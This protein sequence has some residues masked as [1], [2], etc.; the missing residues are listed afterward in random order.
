MEF[1]GKILPVDGYTIKNS[2]NPPLDYMKSLTHLYQPLLGME[3]IMLYQTLLHEADLQESA[4]VQTHHTLMNYLNIA[5]DD[6]YQARLKL[7]GI[8]LLKTF[9]KTNNEKNIYVYELRS[10]FSPEMFFQDAMLTELL[11]HH[12]GKDKYIFLQ[13]HFQKQD[14]QEDTEEITAS[15]HEVF[16][17]FKPTYENNEEVSVE[18]ENRP[19]LVEP[20]NFSWIEMML[21]QRM[22]P[23]HKVLTE[24]NKKMITEMMFLYDLATHEVEK[25]ILWALTEENILD[26][27]EFKLACHDVFK[28]KH[29]QLPIKLIPKVQETEKQTQVKVP[30]TKEEKLIE[31]LKTI[32]PKHLLEDLSGGNRASEQDMKIVREVMTA[33]ALP[34]PVMNVL[35][36]YVLLQSNMRLSK[37]YLEKIAG[38]WSR[39]NFKT[40]EEAF[41]FAREGNKKAQE[42][43]SNKRVYHKKQVSNEIIPDWFE[44]RNKKQSKPIETT[45][46][47]KSQKE[48][49]EIDALLQQLAGE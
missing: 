22:V 12:I 46:D 9:K 13:S 18:K 36:H 21:K 44:D 35:L 15:F 27:E 17:T 49:E 47:P 37:A 28:T 34:A 45:N 11:Y 14:K 29:H 10:P 19:C 26:I 7:E 24:N 25:A 43:Y 41:K 5:L 48:K 3:A 20:I 1:L 33:Q 4:A 8:G 30:Q 31:H 42:G 38:H 32:S 23:T 6:I 16:Q 40:A 39:M 2:G